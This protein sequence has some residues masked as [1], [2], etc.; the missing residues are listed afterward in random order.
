MFQI[1]HIYHVIYIEY[2]FQQKNDDISMRFVVCH[3][4]SG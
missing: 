4:C 2:D 1:I 3:R